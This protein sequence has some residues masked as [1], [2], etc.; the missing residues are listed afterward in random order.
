MEKYWVAA[1]TGLLLQGSQTR[2][3]RPGMPVATLSAA[4]RFFINSEGLLNFTD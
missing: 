2:A 1:A 3:V 4:T